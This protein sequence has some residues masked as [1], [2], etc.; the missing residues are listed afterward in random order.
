M[1]DIVRAE[2]IPHELMDQALYT[3]QD[4]AREMVAAIL[5]AAGHHVIGEASQAELAQRL[6]RWLPADPYERREALADITWAVLA[7]VGVKSL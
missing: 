4:P 1:D 7:M 6:D 2:D 5:F 3:A